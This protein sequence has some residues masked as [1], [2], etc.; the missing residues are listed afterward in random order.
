[1]HSVINT[2]LAFLDFDLRGAAYP[3]DCHSAS[4]F[5]Q[6]LLKLAAVIVGR[7][8]F[9]LL[10][11]LTNAGLDFLLLSQSVD[12]G[13]VIS[14]DANAPGFAENIKRDVLQ[15]N[16]ES[17]GDHLTASQDAMSSSMV[18]RPS[19]N[20]GALTAAILSA[21]RNQFTTS[22]AKT[23]PCTSSEMKTRGRQDCA[24][25]SRTGSNDWRFDS[26]FSKF[27]M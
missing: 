17:F 11:D 12:N 3:D 20:P 23:S 15:L 24:T 8:R 13:R 9:D 7:G 5:R 21:P 25:F 10:L 1:M 22:V 26:C 19:L 14:V 4:H 2:I 18:L 6:P 27:R 16:S